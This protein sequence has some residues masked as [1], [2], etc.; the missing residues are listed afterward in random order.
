MF[1]YTTETM[2]NQ[3]YPTLQQVIPFFHLLLNRLNHFLNC[4]TDQQPDFAA[5]ELAGKPTE[6]AISSKNQ[7]FEI[8]RSKQ[9]VTCPCYF[10]R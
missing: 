7:T 10:N 2:S 3:K 8:L 1:K 5:L 6:I 9:L 4:Q